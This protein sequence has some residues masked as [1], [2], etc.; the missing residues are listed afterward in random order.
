MHAAV[1]RP[2]APARFAWPTCRPLPPHPPAAVQ[3]NFEFGVSRVIKSLE[4]LPAK[5]S[6]DTWYY[7]KRP[8]LALVE[9]LAKHALTFGEEPWGDVDRFLAAAEATGRRLPAVFGGGS[10]GSGGGGGGDGEGRT[11]AEEARRLRSVLRRLA[12]ERWV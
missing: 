4:P 9:G 8:L 11:V 12:E 1:G 5:L 6:P 2:A 7:A 10:G 3:G